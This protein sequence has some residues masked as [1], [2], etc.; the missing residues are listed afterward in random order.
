MLAATAQAQT[1]EVRAT[2]EF[3]IARVETL[4]RA[5]SVAFVEA[6]Q[7]V[8]LQA[9][10]QLQEDPQIS[11]IPLKLNELEALLPAIVEVRAESPA[12]FKVD[13]VLRLRPSQ[14]ALR[15][16]QLRKDPNV[17]A[18]LM[19]LWKDSAD[20]YQELTTLAIEAGTRNLLIDRINV[21]YVVAK[22][23]AALART[24]ESPASARVSS[25]KGRQVA[26]HLAEVAV[27]MGGNFVLAR[28]ALG[29][30]LVESDRPIPAEEQYRQALLS[31]PSSVSAHLQL[32]EALRLQERFAESLE[33]VRETLRLAPSSAPA[34]TD[35]G[36]L[37]DLQRNDEAISEYQAALKLDPD[38]L[39]AHNYL[40]IALA[41]QGKIPEAVE[42]FQQ[43]TRIDPDSVLGYYNLGIALAD[44]EKDD[45]SAE[46]FR[47]AV[48]V[49]PNHFNARYNIADLF[50]LEG[51][52]D[53]S[54][55]QFREYL[56][57]A[58]DTPQN[59]RNIR[60][61]REFVEIHEN[62]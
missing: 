24:E 57:L 16:K 10:R 33:E 12:D 5:R 50:R 54:V 40:A 1:G 41:R 2:R 23:Y 26:R 51:K 15:V 19:E 60:R 6:R 46:A 39:E 27:S 20:S 8:L 21:N 17:V 37:L 43:V 45:E 42:Q 30:A 4:E 36:F 9:V 59:Q 7:S 29:D 38:Y 32:G 56:R 61:A 52:F 58:P 18:R 35:L 47:Q 22:V 28:L 14:I 53:E 13:A 62:R 11:N 31:N 34:H 49:N 44:M 48:R 55:K 3:R 25:A